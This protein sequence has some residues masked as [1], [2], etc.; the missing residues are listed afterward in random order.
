MRAQTATLSRDSLTLPFFALSALALAISSTSIQAQESESRRG[1]AMLLLE[2]I[3]VTARKREE[4]AQ[5]IPLS[6]SAFSSDQIDALKVRDLTNLSVGMPNVA[7]DDI[8]TSKGTANFSVRGLGINSSIPSI[9]PTVG[10]F[11]DGVY[12]GVNNGIIFDTFDLESIEVLRGPQGILFGRNVTGG[13]VLM[14]TKRP[15]DELEVKIRSAI[16]TGGEELNT[17]AMSSISGPIAENLGGKLVV[18]YNN[19][20]GWHENLATGDEF[21][22]SRTKMARGVLDWDVNDNFNLIGRYEYSEGDSD[23]PAAQA[24]TNGSGFSNPNGNF[25]RDSFNFSVNEEGFLKNRTEFFA[26]EGNWDVG[27]GD[28]KITGIFGWR[29]MYQRSNGDIDASSLD[30]F[31]A[32]AW[33]LAEQYSYEL[34][35]NGKF[36]KLNITTGFYHF[37]ND[38]EYHE[39]RV[40]G[41]GASQFDG[42]GKYEVETTGVFVA[43]D[44]DMTE[45]LTLSVGVRYTQEEK[46]AKVKSLSANLGLECNIVTTGDCPFDFV[47]D[48]DWSNV[49]PK[50]GATYQLNEDTLTYAHW[51]R[52][53]RSGGYNLRNTSFDP[54]DTPGPFDEE[55]VDNY[56]VGVKW[57]M[58]KKGRVNAALFYNEIEDMQREINKPGPI[59]VIQLVRNTADAEILGAEVDTTY[60]LTDQ[61]IL[62]A[63]VGY[64]D[65]EYDKVIFDINGDGNI[66]SLDKKLDLPRAAEWTYSVGLS[67]DHPLGEWGYLTSRINYAYRDDSAYTDDNLGTI[68]DQKIVDA[69]I[70]FY[71]NDGHWNIGLYGRNLLDE[72]KHG[73]DTQLPNSLGSTFSPLAKGRVYGIDATYTF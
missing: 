47:D 8:G 2:E 23:G 20:D 57:E 65:A 40:I 67:H 5:D 27:F 7:L 29:D 34:R 52:G 73:G 35:Y 43:A 11:V 10:I 66:D 1:S 26:L 62:T 41:F 13:A 51:S 39:R 37:T 55:K 54:A 16:E 30:L 56:E 60:A 49:S 38:M 12:M 46:D 59:G 15:G 9:D 63:S 53:Y 31:Y 36:N 58:G 25:N 48:E 18:Y 61:L 71:S 44:Y 17:Y 50:V 21:G 69:G 68:D 45:L 19:D 72:V 32:P 22:E 42:G 64:I 33:L 24:H 4:S 70:D 3:T 28:G 6:V 14:K